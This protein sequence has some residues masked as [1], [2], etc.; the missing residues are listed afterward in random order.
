MSE[1]HEEEKKTDWLMEFREPTALEERE[2]KDWHA[3]MAA[4]SESQKET[5]SKA[6]AQ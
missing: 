3:R 2:A 6:A 5:S 4:K 1:T